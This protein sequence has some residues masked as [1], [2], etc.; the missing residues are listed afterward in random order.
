M[1]VFTPAGVFSTRYRG[2]RRSATTYFV[3]VF[4]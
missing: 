1:V 2:A 3:L 4:P